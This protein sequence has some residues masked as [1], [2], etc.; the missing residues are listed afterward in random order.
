MQLRFLTVILAGLL[1]LPGFGYSQGKKDKGYQY[2]VDLTKVVDDRIYVELTPPAVS[3]EE[4]TF[5]LPKIV[6]GTYAIADYGRYIDQ[7]KALD[8]KG[9][10]LPVEKVDVNSW[11]IKN[12][13]KLAK[14]SYWVDDSFD[15]KKDGP[16]IFWPAGT[17]IE[18]SKNF[19]LN[20]SGFFGYLEGKKDVNFNFNVIRAKDLYGS[21]GLIPVSTGAT[22]KALKLEKIAEDNSK[23]VDVYSTSNYDQLVDS[24]LM[25]AKADTAVIRV[26]NTQVLIGSYSP[27]NMVTAKE[28]AASIREVLKAQA[29]FLGG[30]LPV[31]KYAF[32]FYFT[33]QPVIS[34]GALEHSYSSLYYM[35][36]MPISEMNQQLRDFAAHEFF[37]IV[38]PLT[39]HSKEI[40]DFDFNNPKMSQ[41]LWMYEG[42]TEYFAGSVQVKYDLISPEQ[43]LEIIREKMITSDQFLNDVP[44]TDISKFTLDKYHD[45][46]YNVYQKGALIGMC[47]DIKLRKLSNGK[48]GV[49]NLMMDLSK[50]Y[51]KEKAFDDSE[52]FDEIT[53]MTYPQ[54][55]DFFTRYVKGTEKLPLAEVLNE[56]GVSYQEE[57]K[58]KDFSIGITN[59]DLGVTEIDG[60]PRLQIA[61]TKNLNATGKALAFQEG[62]IIAKINGEN[63]P[64]LGPELGAFIQRQFISLQEGKNLTYGVLRKNEKG[65]LA[66]VTL[67]TPAVKVDMARRHL[68]KFN[69]EATAEQLALRK[70]WLRP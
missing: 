3:G 30:K 65:E 51:G 69:A 9:K 41:H 7:F 42:M 44:F 2:T 14:I 25:Y 55:G 61:S 1:I 58:F 27:N 13:G 57:E 59:A 53:K 24:P 38:T 62:D 22:P 19:V 50:K 4:I 46:Y 40:A 48:Y 36:E 35:P 12:A 26:A 43:Y 34:Y 45:Q 52:L 15:T 18:A 6:P 10:E 49:Q 5:Y 67:S 68:I 16:E 66:E 39:V 47:L 11:K 37:H 33:D 31:D 63:L 64:E 20:T 32:I 56:V 70:A 17:N 28:I 8:K 54:I 29:A 21:T 60:K 23:Q